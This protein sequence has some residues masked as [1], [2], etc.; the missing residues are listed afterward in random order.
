MRRLTSIWRRSIQARVVTSTIVL[1][2]LVISL[3]GWALLRDVAGGLA[4]SRRIA[5]I[6]EAR[7][8]DRPAGVGRCDLLLACATAPTPRSWSSCSSCC[9]VPSRKKRPRSAHDRRA[10]SPKADLWVCWWL[11]PVFY[12]L[13]GVIFVVL[14]RVMPPPRPGV[15]VEQIND[16]FDQHETTIKIGFG[17][18]M[19]L[20]GL[21]SVTNVL[22]AVQMKRMSVKPVFAYAYITTLAVGAVPGCLVRGLRVRR[23]R[24]PPRP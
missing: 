3:T 4:D 19:V 17:L 2:A 24:V 16:F 20:I 14:A 15:G 23:R 13:F 11:F 10:G 5:A 8:Q 6:S 12:T 9:A 22:V 1:S 7:S 21:A 18:L